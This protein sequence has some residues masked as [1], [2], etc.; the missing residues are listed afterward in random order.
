ME[1]YD[2]V[3]KCKHINLSTNYLDS[4]SCDTPYCSW[5]EEHCSDCGAYIVK[6]G[7]G[8]YNS[9]S[10]WPYKRYKKRTYKNDR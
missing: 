4:G 9:I 3:L 1:F 7:C 5:Y 6:C 2:K 8:F 10:G